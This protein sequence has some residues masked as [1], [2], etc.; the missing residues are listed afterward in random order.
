MVD[1]LLIV[2]GIGAS[3]CGYLGVRWVRT[4]KSIYY[5]CRNVN[6]R[7]EFLKNNRESTV[8]Q[9]LEKFRT[10]ASAHPDAK[11]IQGSELI[12]GKVVSGKQIALQALDR[13]SLNKKS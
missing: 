6:Q 13:N 7:R 2:L 1:T 12:E 8:R 5:Y 10:I 9:V 11:I 4:S 3:F